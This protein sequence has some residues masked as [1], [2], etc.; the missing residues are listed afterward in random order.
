[1]QKHFWL[2]FVSFALKS[3]ALTIEP[4]GVIGNSG[5]IHSTISRTGGGVAV[6]AR[7]KGPGRV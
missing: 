4:V 2:F 5:D 1:M 6:D 7:G 3:A